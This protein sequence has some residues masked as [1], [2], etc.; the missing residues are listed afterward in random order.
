[1]ELRVGGIGGPSPES[2]LQCDAAS[3]VPTWRSEH[4]ARSMVRHNAGDFAT[5]VY[6]WR[7]LTSGSRSFAIWPLLLPF[8]LLNVAGWMG[9]PIT[10]WRGKAHR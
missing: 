3:V 5:H 6:D 9:P 2:I 8:T 4:L 10:S 7:P 1:M